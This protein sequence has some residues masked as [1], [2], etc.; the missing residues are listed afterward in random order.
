[1]ISKRLAYLTAMTVLAAC[2]VIYVLNSRERT[3]SAHSR[4]V[5]AEQEPDRGIVAK[6][7][8]Y[9][10]ALKLVHA[11]T[12]NAVPYLVVALHQYAMDAH[13]AGLN[14]T[15][16]AIHKQLD[17][18]L[19]RVGSCQSPV[20]EYSLVRRVVAE[21]GRYAEHL[22]AMGNDT[23]ADQAV[24]AMDLAYLQV[25]A[26]RPVVMD[27]VL[28][29]IMGIWQTCATTSVRI[30]AHGSVEE[31]ARTYIRDRMSRY[32]VHELRPKV[33]S[34]VNSRD[35]TDLRLRLDAAEAS[36]ATQEVARL[37]RL[38]FD[39]QS[40]FARHLIDDW[41]REMRHATSDCRHTFGRA[42]IE[43]ANRER[44]S[45]LRLR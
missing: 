28:I 26:D 45:L 23:L 19:P 11:Q 44:H 36:G 27:H 29:G 38:L 5:V 21:T 42:K 16:V 30:A 4:S 14:T 3:S 40:T 31:K 15:I 18:E 25:M 22:H 10:E 20:P 7:M 34:F 43:M 37:R 24:N 12:S 1:M 6:Q 9:G 8:P 2:V 32:L 41:D 39:R 35:M 17:A 13:S 33:L